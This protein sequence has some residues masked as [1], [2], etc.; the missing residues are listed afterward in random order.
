AMFFFA[1]GDFWRLHVER[2]QVY[3]FHLLALSA[4]V[5]LCLRRNSAEVLPPPPSR[6]RV[7][8]GRLDSPSP[9]P[10]R[11]PPPPPPRHLPPSPPPPRAL[12]REGGGSHLAS[13]AAGVAF[14]VAAA[15]R[16]NLIVLAPAFLVLGKWRTG[17]GTL[18]TAAVAVAATLPLAPPGVWRSY[19]EMGDRN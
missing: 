1:F 11:V 13:W 5:Y 4:G 17:L 6:G 10:P 8:S 3:A 18:L 15:F 14:G 7:A 19:L 16:P 9:P 12:P 2:G